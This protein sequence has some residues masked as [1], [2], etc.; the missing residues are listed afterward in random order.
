MGTVLLTASRNTSRKPFESSCSFS[1]ATES[2]SS[3]FSPPL[4]VTRNYTIP[5]D[6]IFEICTIRKD[7]VNEMIIQKENLRIIINVFFYQIPL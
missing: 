4:N 7:V 5:E 6:G 3:T 1:L 2:P